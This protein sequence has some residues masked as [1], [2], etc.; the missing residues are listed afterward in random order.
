[1]FMNKQIDDIDDLD[2]LDKASIERKWHDDIVKGF[3][4]MTTALSANN[5]KE[6]I[7][8]IKGQSDILK[9]GMEQLVKS[10]PKPQVNE[11]FDYEKIVTSFKDIS[12]KSEDK[13]EAL[14]GKF[15]ETLNNRLLPDTFTL[16]K[17]YGGTTES[18]KVNYKQANNITIK[19]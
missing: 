10:I 3:S 16:V 13:F 5:D 2:D 12:K 7:S 9:S 1:M 17:N 4:N 14:V 19:K 18:V 6:I 8:A 11:V 15:I